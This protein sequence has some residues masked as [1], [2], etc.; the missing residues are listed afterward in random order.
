MSDQRNH[1]GPGGHETFGLMNIQEIFEDEQTKAFRKRVYELAKSCLEQYCGVTLELT[2]CEAEDDSFGKKDERPHCNVVLKKDDKSCK[3]Y[4][5]NRTHLWP[6]E[7]VERRSSPDGFS[8]KVLKNLSPKM[9]IKDRDGLSHF[10]QKEQF[11][12]IRMLIAALDEANPKCPVVTAIRQHLQELI[13]P[14]TNED[15][16]EGEE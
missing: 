2:D 11:T 12:G 10:V 4:F 16:T 3:A 5:D 1:H 8:C 13:N 7:D 15:E 6:K 9:S 14:P